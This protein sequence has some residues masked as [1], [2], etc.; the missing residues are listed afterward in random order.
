MESRP[1]RFATGE[2][3]AKFLETVSGVE[4]KSGDKFVT[5]RRD[6]SYGD[7]I[8]ETAAGRA[9]GGRYYT[10][11]AVRKALAPKELVKSGSVMRVSLERKAFVDV[12]DA[13]RGLGALLETTE[14]QDEASAIIRQGTGE[15]ALGGDLWRMAGA[16]LRAGQSVFI[17]ARVVAAVH[18]VAERMRHMAPEGTRIGALGKF[19]PLPDGKVRAWFTDK[20][21][22]EAS[23]VETWERMRMFRA[24]HRNGTIYAFEATLGDEPVDLFDKRLAAKLGHEAVHALIWKARLVGRDLARLVAHGRRLRVLDMQFGTYLRL[25]VDPDASHADPS[26]TLRDAYLTHYAGRDDL[27]TALREEHATHLVEFYMLGHLSAAEIAPVKAIIVVGYPGAGKSTIIAA[28]KAGM[29]AAHLTADDAKLIVPEYD[30]GRGNQHVFVESAD[31]IK[32]GENI[33]IET[34][35]SNKA[36]VEARAEILRAAG[37]TVGVVGVNVPKA[38]AMERAV[39]RFLETGRAVP[40]HLYDSLDPGATYARAIESGTF[41][42]R[43]KIDWVEGRGWTVSEA[44]GD[45]EALGKILERQ[46]LRD[47]GVG[48]RGR[49]GSTEAPRQAEFGTTPEAGE[50]Q[51]EPVAASARRP[52]GADISAQRQPQQAQSEPEEPSAEP[53]QDDRARRQLGAAARRELNTLSKRLVGKDRAAWAKEAGRLS[54]LAARVEAAYGETDL[55]RSTR[56]SLEALGLLKGAAEPTVSASETVS[57]AEA[58]EPASASSKK[59]KARIEDAGEKIG[60]ARKETVPVATG[61]AETEPTSE[62]SATP[63][64]RIRDRL[65]GD[66]FASILDARRFAAEAG[67]KAQTSKDVDEAIERAAVL[68]ARQI[69]AEGSDPRSVR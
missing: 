8:V 2:Q 61:E 15:A 58:K 10:D 64:E 38:I 19:E 60:K 52:T 41:D 18:G 12:V 50:P 49:L 30:K 3:V 68:A 27:Q 57:K 53:A 59:D 5:L 24:F 43:A 13:I 44:S 11:P 31:L 51:A 14:A 37:Y 42:T 1:V 26:A 47:T 32:A 23:F 48:G 56:A 25:V 22:R 66:G 35:G 54:E 4:V 69:V 36:S 46:A 63:I 55:V 7:F 62:P 29:R 6:R 45:L 67:L 9:T 16:R 33:I 65:L 34:I 28:I 20:N 39:S 40:A 21:G 17:P